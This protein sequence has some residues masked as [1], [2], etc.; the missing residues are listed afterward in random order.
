VREETK[1]NRN[2]MHDFQKKEIIVLGQQTI[3]TNVFRCGR[4]YESLRGDRAQLRVLIGTTHLG[5]IPTYPGYYS[6]RRKLDLSWPLDGTRTGHS[7]TDFHSQYETR[8]IVF[9]VE[10]ILSRVWV[11]NL[12]H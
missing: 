12:L 11:R 7:A 9:A 10:Y 4:M 6:P 5:G 8:K 3:V 1:P 2:L